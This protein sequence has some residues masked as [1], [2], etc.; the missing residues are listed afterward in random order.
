MFE[1]RVLSDLNPGEIERLL[2]EMGCDEKG[3]EIMAPKADVLLV[4]AKNLDPRAA[5][6]VKQ[7]FLSSGG[8]A[9]VPW[10][11]LDLSDEKSDILMMGTPVQYERVKEKLR[12]Q[13]FDLGK[14][15]DEIAESI[16]Y[17]YSSPQLPWDQ[18][19]CEVM[20]VLNVTPDSFYDGGKHETVDRAV[21]RGIDM[22]E[23]GADIIDIGGESTRPGS[24]RISVEEELG[25]IIPVIK[26][27]APKVDIPM[28]VDTYKPEV[29]EEAVKAGASIVN[30]VFGLRKEGMAEKVAELDVPVIIM[31]MQGEPKNMQEEPRYENVIEDISSFFY[32][33]IE[34]AESKGVDKNN[35]IIDPGIGF[36]KKLEHNLEIIDRLAEFTSLGYPVL[37][38]ASRKSF[39]G[40]VLDKKAE[41][42]LYGSLAVA[43]SAV[44]SGASILRVHDV[45]ETLD[46]VQTMKALNRSSYKSI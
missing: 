34:F 33:R 11:A 29:A 9:A 45:Q 13:P 12:E 31:H 20:G 28:S 8:E 15:A 25:R 27:L 4:Y 35:I 18:E 42:R 44:E 39:L 2:S 36:G 7:E 30:D 24:D 37:L 1:T 46:V 40:D 26:R 43:A 6:I 14:L 19:R 3:V 22:S 21:E 32:E 17:H 16:Q 23:K 38:G 41:E 5:N 10:E